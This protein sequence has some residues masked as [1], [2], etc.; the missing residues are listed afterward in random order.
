[1]NGVVLRSHASIVAVMVTLSAL[2]CASCG[3]HDSPRVAANGSASPNLSSTSPLLA[4]AGVNATAQSSPFPHPGPIFSAAPGCS[5]ISPASLRQ[6]GFDFDTAVESPPTALTPGDRCFFSNGP[7]RSSSPSF[8]Y[9]LYAPGDPY[10]KIIMSDASDPTMHESPVP[11]A[12]ARAFLA[13]SVDGLG[14]VSGGCLASNGVFLQAQVWDPS[15]VTTARKNLIAVL[16]YGC[17]HAPA[18]PSEPP[19]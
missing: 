10:A 12:G 17:A 9:W 3:G 11:G 8:D 13:P 5:L 7:L 18:M 1:M 4:S 19:T 6:L 15:N 16:K 2:T 14:L